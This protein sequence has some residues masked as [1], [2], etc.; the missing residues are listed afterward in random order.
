MSI[1]NLAD[2]EFPNTPMDVAT[3]DEVRT[4][5][6]KASA[7][8]TIALEEAGIDHSRSQEGAAV[9]DATHNLKENKSPEEY[10]DIA[11]QELSY[12]E[13]EVDNSQYQSKLADVRKELTKV[14]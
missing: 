1:Q 14:I 11:I 13:S 9:T 8:V 2:L 5:V 6:V 12:A 3:N 4:A 7:Y 10:I